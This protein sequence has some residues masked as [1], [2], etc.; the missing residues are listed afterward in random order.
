MFSIYSN[1]L[2]KTY[3]FLNSFSG[4]FSLNKENPT[5]SLN[6]NIILIK[7]DFK[8]DYL[9]YLTQIYE[10]KG[11]KLTTKK[12]NKYIYCDKENC[13]EYELSR[14][15]FLTKKYILLEFKK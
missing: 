14:R 3:N 11:W 15:K 7:E 9:N 5:K 8:E 12:E 10:S 1:G 6:E 13:D 4:V 2:F